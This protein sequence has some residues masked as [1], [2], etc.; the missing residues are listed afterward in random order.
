MSLIIRLNIICSLLMLLTSGLHGDE[1]EK[2]LLYVAQP[3]IRNYVQYG[4]HGIIV[5]DIDNNHKFVKRIPMGGLT[6]QGKPINVKGVCA[7]A[8]SGR[9]YV[10]TLKHLIAIDLL[11]DKQL[12]ERT[13]PKGC[14]RMSIT[15]DGKTIFL[16]SLEKDIWYVVRAE[17]GEVI[18]IIQPRSRSHNT[19]VGL[20]GQ[21]AYLAGLGSPFLT[22]ADVNQQKAIRKVGPFSHSIRPFTINAQQTHC[23]VN[24]NKLLGFEVGDMKTGKKL[25]RVEVKGFKMGPVKR[26]GCP[27]HGIGMTPD[28]KEIWVTDGHN[29]YMHIFD[30]TVMP[31]KQFHSIKVREQPGWVTFTI[32][33]DLAY[34]STGEVIEVKTKKIIHRLF[35]EKGRMMMSEKML[36]IDFKGGK[37]I[38]NG[39]QFGL[40]R[41]K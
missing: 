34:P 38:R 35:D 33:G 26:H 17:D 12:W 19:I 39:D 9:L 30:A 20:D 36:E 37:P 32:K 41:V 23:F 22:I 13:Y 5:F 11:T 8:Q 7:H 2:R 3:G 6:P 14:D 27:S 28:E 29:E 24:V 4:G 1:N 18:K 16:P 40:G 31:P 21:F 15:P 10:S 25:H